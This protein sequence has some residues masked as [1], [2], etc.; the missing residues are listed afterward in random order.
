[1]RSFVHA[2]RGIAILVA[3]ERNAR[4]HV[5]AALAV[6]A[7][8]LRLGVSSAEWCLL[9]LAIGF[10]FS[11][12]A[13]NTGI[14]FVCDALHPEQHPLIGKAKDVAAAGVLLAAI[15]AAVV[16]AVIFVPL[17]PFAGLSK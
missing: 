15:S 9:V 7:A 13:L 11:A 1:M 14:E 5:V 12:E 8:G 10:V 3:S 2:F 6:V 16:G 17:L 4:I